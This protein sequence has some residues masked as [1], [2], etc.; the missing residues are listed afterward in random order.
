MLAKE[1]RLKKEIKSLLIAEQ[2]NVIMTHCIK[3]KIDNTHH[4]DKCG[5]C[6]DG[7]E[8]VICLISKCNKQ[9][10]KEYKTGHDLVGKE[11]PGNCASD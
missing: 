5:L 6:R 8:S 7:D 10:Q 11:V 1:R 3:A 2:N 9:A 4:N